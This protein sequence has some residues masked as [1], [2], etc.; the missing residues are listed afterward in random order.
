VEKNERKNEKSKK[1]KGQILKGL[2]WMLWIGLIG[3]VIIFALKGMWVFVGLI[4]LILII[5]IAKAVKILKGDEMAV[6]ERFGEPIEFRDSGLNFIIPFIDEL[7]LFPKT[8]FAFEYKVE[9]FTKEEE[10]IVGEIKEKVKETSDETEK[11]NSKSYKGIPVIVVVTAYVNFPRER[12]KIE[13]LPEEKQKEIAKK[14]SKKVEEIQN[15]E[16]ET[17]PLII[18]RRNNIPTSEEGLKEYVG[19]IIEGIVRTTVGGISYGTLLTEKQEV[20]TKL[21][22]HLIDP[23]GELI[24]SGFSA[25]GLSIVIKKIELPEEL[26]KRLA[27]FE[28]EKK[29]AEAAPWE[30]EQRTIETVGAIAKSL[31]PELS[32]K[33]AMEKFASEHKEK[34]EIAKELIEKEMAIKR[35][36]YKHI[37]FSSEGSDFGSNFGKIAAQ[38]AAGIAAGMEA[39]K[40]GTREEKKEERVERVEKKNPHP[41]EKM[42]DAQIT[43]YVREKAYKWHER[44]KKQK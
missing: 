25:N 6:L 43:E 19:G 10:E 44:K 42:T 39:I 29:E 13:E 40:G 21:K 14:K 23:E 17:H 33:K 3:L 16:E 26:K 2:S 32:V 7:I 8:R 27:L 30:S 24:L 15:E 35:G 9:C 1:L 34:L 12:R 5:V 18:I 37:H 11:E 31:Y 36:V 4:G 38:I 22:N 28:I 41:L 20:E